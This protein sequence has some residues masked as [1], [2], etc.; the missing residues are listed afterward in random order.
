MGDFYEKPHFTIE[1]F[2][3]WEAGDEW[4]LEMFVSKYQKA[5]S[6][7][8]S[9]RINRS[10]YVPVA[11]FWILYGGEKKVRENVHWKLE[12][13]SYITLSRYSASDSVL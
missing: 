12:S 8:K 11:L 2:K 7:A 6:Y 4:R 1:N 3:L 9:G 5:H 13:T 10:A